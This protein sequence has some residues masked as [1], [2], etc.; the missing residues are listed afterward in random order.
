MGK[1]A[2]IRFA[3]LLQP[4]DFFIDRWNE[5]LYFAVYIIRVPI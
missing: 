4:V 3:I 5:V 2:S 1:L